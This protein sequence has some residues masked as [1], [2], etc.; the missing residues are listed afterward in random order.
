MDAKYELKIYVMGKVIKARV[1]QN[2][3]M[4]KIITMLR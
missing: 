3:K 2:E 1:Q 4:N